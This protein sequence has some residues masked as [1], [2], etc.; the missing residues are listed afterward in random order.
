M[1]P[2]SLERKMFIAVPWTTSSSYYSSSSQ[3][4][5]GGVFGST[6]FNF[7]TWVRGM[8]ELGGGSRAKLVHLVLRVQCRTHVEMGTH[9]KMQTNRSAN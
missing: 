9:N 3:Y 1:L 7:F 8:S 2:L 5:V 6:L 4:T